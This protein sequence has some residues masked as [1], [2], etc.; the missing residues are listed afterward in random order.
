MVR[1]CVRL[2]M[3]IHLYSRWFVWAHWSMCACVCLLM[4][5]L[6][7]VFMFHECMSACVHVWTCARMHVY[8]CVYV[9]TH[10]CIWVCMW[11]CMYIHIYV[12]VC[13]CV[14]QR[15][16]DGSHPSSCNKTLCPPQSLS[17]GSARSTFY[18]N[19]NVKIEVVIWDP[20]RRWEDGE[21]WELCRSK[22]AKEDET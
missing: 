4:H 12:C 20:K 11:V 15:G 1:G 13:V 5:S 14:P 19:I 7:C 9:R 22:L 16:S 10:V 21:D 6:V 8:V 17:W 3:L 2:S 18:I